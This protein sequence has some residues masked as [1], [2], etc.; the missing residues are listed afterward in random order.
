VVLALAVLHGCNPGALAAQPARPAPPADVET[1]LLAAQEA[2]LR[3]VLPGV[4]P[5]GQRAAAADSQPLV[6]CLAL[7]DAAD[8]PAPMLARLTAARVAVVARRRCPPTFASWYVVVD[9]LG[10]RVD[11]PTPPG[12]DPVALTVRAAVWEGSDHVRVEV[13]ESYGTARARH[14]CRARRRADAAWEAR[15]GAP[16]RAFS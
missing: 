10:R 14:V 6:I 3:A 8:P 2:A 11:P 9:S 15:C 4:G 16:L 7:R 13:D 5:L 12:L 1:L